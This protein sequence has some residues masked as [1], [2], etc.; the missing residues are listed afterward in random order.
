MFEKQDILKNVIGSK[1]KRG[2][3]N[4]SVNSFRCKGQISYLQCQRDNELDVSAFPEKNSFFRGRFSIQIFNRSA[5][6]NKFEH[7]QAA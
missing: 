3:H 1:N 2:F 7:K 4:F 5:F 6:K